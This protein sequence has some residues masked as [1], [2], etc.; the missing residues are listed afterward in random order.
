MDY[1]NAILYGLPDKQLMRL[2]KQQNNAA[3]LILLKK[4]HDHISDDLKHL[5]WLKIEERILLK[6]LLIMYKIKHNKA[7]P[8]LSELIKPY[9]PSRA[10]RSA[11]N[12][13]LHEPRSH[14]TF[15][16]RAF[17]VIGPK[18]WNKLPK[19]IRQNPSIA[20]FKKQLKTA[21]FKVSYD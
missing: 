10:L 1:C 20:C 4:K 12:E 15:G 7:P 19:S 17:Q 18:K 8:Y 6:I 16:D 11:D 2:Q 3:R 21:L 5:Y 9:E 14:N 13:L